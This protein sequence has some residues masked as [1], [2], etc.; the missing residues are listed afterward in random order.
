MQ[1]VE[2]AA[3]WEPALHA[4][5]ECNR[6]PRLQ[7]D[8]CRHVAHVI[9]VVRVALDSLEDPAPVPFWQ[10]LDLCGIKFRAPHA[11]Y[12]NLTHWLISTQV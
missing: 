3:D 2:R 7:P 6:L 9:G 5:L 11:I 1:D 10:G 12:D 4:R 8:R